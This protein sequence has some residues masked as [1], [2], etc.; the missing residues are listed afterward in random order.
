MVSQNTA[1]AMAA[2]K[3][4]GYT[5]QGGKLTK[6]GKQASITISMPNNFTD[7]V[8]AATEVKT[9]LGKVGI[10]VTLD[11]P[12]YAQYEKEIGAGTFDAAIGGFGGS[13]SP[14]TDFN[15]ALN[16]KYA[17]PINTATVNNF[18]R[19]KDPAVDQRARQP[20]CGDVAAGTAAG[21]VQAR[22]DTCTT[23]SRSSCSTT[24]AAGACSRRRTSPAGRRRA[25]RTSL[26][27]TYNNAM[28]LI[29]THLKKAYDRRMRYALRTDQDRLVRAHA[30]GRRSR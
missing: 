8:A 22:A 17:A 1:Q 15:N 29:V 20:G 2:F 24:A 6:G 13:G 28:L 14:Y 26:P 9:E 16:S 25:I 12:Q 5:M 19:F 4:A 23:S 30:C 27:T 21:D 18:E 11:E 7:W 3:K 10:A